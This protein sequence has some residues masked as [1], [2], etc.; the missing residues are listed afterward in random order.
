MRRPASGKAVI[1][2]VL[3]VVTA[4][5]LANTV[6]GWQSLY[7]I[8]P[9]T[10]NVAQLFLGAG[11]TATGLLAIVNLL[12]RRRRNPIHHSPVPPNSTNLT[13]LTTEE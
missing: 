3:I 8:G 1:V 10:G 2:Y 12:R 7:T 13:Q 4:F 9:D 6:L 5:N 11:A